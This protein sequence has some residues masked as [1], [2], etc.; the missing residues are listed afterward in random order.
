MTEGLREFNTI[1]TPQ[2]LTKETYTHILIYYNCY[3]YETHVTKDCQKTT[4]ICSECTETGHNWTDCT[5]TTKK[6]INCIRTDRQYTDNRTL[7]TKYPYRNAIIDA[8]IQKPTDKLNKDNNK[9]Y[10]DIA[11]EA[12]RQAKMED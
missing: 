12:V 6:C 2:K 3:E 8:K 11:R 9:T 7:A 10:S 4:I 5:N 1:I